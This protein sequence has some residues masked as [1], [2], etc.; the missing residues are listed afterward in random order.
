MHATVIGWLVGRS[1]LHHVQSWNSDVERALRLK[2]IEFLVDV[3]G[4]D[5]NVQVT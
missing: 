3:C 4:A 5:V 1:C 2:V